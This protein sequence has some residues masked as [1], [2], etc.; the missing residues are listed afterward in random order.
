MEGSFLIF[1]GGAD[2]REF[3]GEGA[4]RGRTRHYSAISA[5][6]IKVP[7]AFE[8]L[9][10]GRR[11]AVV[12]L[13]PD[14]SFWFASTARAEDLADEP[15][16]IEALVGTFGDWHSPVPELI[17]ATADAAS[18]GSGSSDLDHSRLL[19]EESAWGTHPANFPAAVAGA[20]ADAKTCAIGDAR[21]RM[22]AN[23]AQGAAM[24]VE[25]AAELAA[26]L[27]EFGPTPDA[28]RAF[29][30]RRSRRV[31]CC[32]AATRFTE[33]IGAPCGSVAEAARDAA[34]RC[35]PGKLFDATLWLSLGAGYKSPPPTSV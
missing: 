15:W 2:P 16:D 5:L 30:A 35:V 29:L 3:S 33:L 9:G 13:G 10:S 27:A 12:P 7:Q 17:L 21:I 24:A 19:I 34:L 26:A 22:P 4:T 23:L 31:S 8:S 28:T 20:D 1:A 11:F 25:E 6:P 14:S 18:S 32:A